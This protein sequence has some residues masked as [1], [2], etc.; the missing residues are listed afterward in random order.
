MQSNLDA[1]ERGSVVQHKCEAPNSTPSTA[2]PKS[3]AYWSNK[4]LSMGKACHKIPNLG[5]RHTEA[6]SFINFKCKLNML[7]FGVI[8]YMNI[9]W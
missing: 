4:R 6:K 3:K 5:N 2:K 9:E 7:Y 8:L 1:N